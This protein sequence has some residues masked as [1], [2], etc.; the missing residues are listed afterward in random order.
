MAQ[1]KTC[2]KL[3]RRRIPKG[4]PSPVNYYAKIQINSTTSQFEKFEL[5]FFHPRQKLPSLFFLSQLHIVFPF[6]PLKA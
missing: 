3:K 5:N 2:A 6:T 1:W 4:C